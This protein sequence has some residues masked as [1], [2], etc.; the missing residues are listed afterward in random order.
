MSFPNH[1]PAYLR[2]LKARLK[3]FKRPAFW[4]SASGLLLVLLFTWEYW[5]NPESFSILGGASVTGSNT[6]DVKPTL[7]AEE[8]AA[9]TTDIDNSSVFLE[10]FNRTKALSLTTASNQKP[11][12]SNTGGLFTQ[13]LPQTEV[14][15]SNPAS[16]SQTLSLK[17]QQTANT[18]NPFAKSAQGL[19]NPSSVS[20]SVLFT[21]RNPT[22][23]P[24]SSTGTTADSPLGFNTS[25]G[26][27]SVSPLQSAL[28]RVAATNALRATNETQTPTNIQRQA[29]PTTTYQ[30]QTTYPATT[31]PGTT[32]YSVAPTT[33]PNSFTYLVPPQPTTNVP[34][35]IPTTPVVP[36]TAGSYGQYSTQPP[37]QVNG[38]TNPGFNSTLTSPGS[39]PSQLSQPTFT[40]PN[41]VPGQYIGGGQINTFSNP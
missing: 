2:Y 27:V 35:A 28:D 13:T 14:T 41:P 11:Q 33:P 7:P 4:A 40:T 8:L 1:H 19:L 12:S 6:P 16:N 36:T 31:V 38:M 9:I 22:N 3:P 29:S 30:G 25:P 32:G 23:Q 39:Q 17:P 5:K 26:T 20:E 18:T 21:N 37:I 34:G 10:E 15:D 24:S